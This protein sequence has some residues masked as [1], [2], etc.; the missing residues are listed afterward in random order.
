MFIVHLYIM[1][2]DGYEF[3]LKREIGIK[4]FFFKKGIQTFS[5][6]FSS[7]FQATAQKAASPAAAAVPVAAAAAPAAEPATAN[8]VDPEKAKQ[9]SQ[10]V[11]EQ[12]RQLSSISDDQH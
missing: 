3:E 11:T 10:A 12:V 1:S 4:I 8:G 7:C 6:F 2:R 5:F 9:L